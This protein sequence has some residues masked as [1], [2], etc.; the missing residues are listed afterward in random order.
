MKLCAIHLKKI[1][2]DSV[3]APAGI[4]R[5]IA[6]V[7]MTE[8]INRHNPETLTMIP[9]STT[10]SNDLLLAKQSTIEL[11]AFTKKDYCGHT[12][13]YWV[14]TSGLPFIL[15]KDELIP[16]HVESPRNKGVLKHNKDG[17]YLQIKALGT[18]IH[19]LV[20]ILYVPGR[21]LIHNQVDHIDNFRYNN[22]ASN[23]RWVSQSENIR[24]YYD[25]RRRA[26][27]HAAKVES[28]ITNH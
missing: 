10:L 28:L 5:T 4:V 16:A 17:A 19:R 15:R 11:R 7:P 22:A 21:D 2:S 1:A 27:E 18:T 8:T 13:T 6:A 3:A 9:N 20:A 23:L 12:R 14:T 25:F 24:A 26:L